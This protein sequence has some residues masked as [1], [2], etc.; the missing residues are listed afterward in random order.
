[1]PVPELLFCAVCQVSIAR[2]EVERGAARRTPRGRYFCTACSGASPEDRARRRAA[3]EAEF[4]DD[5][6]VPVPAPTPRAAAASAVRTRPAP[7]APRP[8]PPPPAERTADA[9]LDARVG[10]LERAAFRMQAR[11]AALEE[12]LDAVHRGPRA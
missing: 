5:A 1:M 3:L 12:K 6:P 4:A 11:I 8:E 2:V 9:V 7:P 10:E